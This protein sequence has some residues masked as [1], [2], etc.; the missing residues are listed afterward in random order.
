M[1]FKAISGEIISDFIYKYFSS[2]YDIDKN[3]GGIILVSEKRY[4]KIGRKITG[5][6]K[7]NY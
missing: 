6:K 4:E 2:G 3:R 5:I 1:N 7:A